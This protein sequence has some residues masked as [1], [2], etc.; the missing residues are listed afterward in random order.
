MPLRLALLLALAAALLAG[1]R[2]SAQTAGPGGVTISADGS[3]RVLAPA[4]LARLPRVTVTAT[5]HGRTHRYQ[6]VPLAELLARGGAAPGGSGTGG[7][8][9]ARGGPRGPAV[10]RFVVVT[11]SD[12][13]RAVL[14][15]AEIDSATVPT[16]PGGPVVL[17]DRVDGRPLA[18]S[19]GPLRLVVPGDL[20]P[21]RSVRGVVRIEVRSAP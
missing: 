19:D 2:L 10:A 16:A 8:H 17:A 1:G 3:S 12:G 13:Y 14:A 5:Q 7:A 21:A 9:G 20:R 4:E 11:G 15:L 18:G 6:G